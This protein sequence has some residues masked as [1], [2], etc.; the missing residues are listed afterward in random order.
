[1]GALEGA[2]IT[3]LSKGVDFHGQDPFAADTFP[4]GTTLLTGNLS[5]TGTL[6]VGDSNP[7]CKSGTSGANLFPSNFVCNPTTID[8]R[9]VTD[10]SQG[11]GAIFVHGWGHYLQIANNRVMNNAGTLGGG[12]NV[13][14]GEFPGAY[15]LGGVNADPGSC[16]TTSS[17]GLTNSIQPY[18]HE[19]DVNV[20]NNM[21][22]NNSSTGDELFSAT[23]AGAGGV[24]F[25]TGSDYYKFNNNWVCGNLGTG[26]GGGLGHLG[27]SYSADIEHNTFLFNQSTNP[28]I[29]TNGGAIVIMGAPDVDPT[30]GA[31]T[32]QD[33]VPTPGSIGPSD[34]TGPHTVINA[35][36]FVGNQA[37][38]GSGGA[39]ALQQI[40]GSDIV[41]FP[42]N[43]RAWNDVTVTNNIINNNVAG[44]D[45][46]GISLLD[47]LNVN[48]VNNTIASN[49]STASAGPL[50][51]T[52]G[53][54]LASTHGT[55]CHNAS[56]TASC[57]QPAGLVTEPNSAVLIAN[58]PA[59]ITCPANHFAGT[60]ASNGTCRSISYPEL[61]NN[62]IWQNRS[63]YIGVSAPTAG[64]TNQQNQ[65]TLFNAFGTTLAPSQPQ[66]DATT[67]NGNGIIV[68]GGTGACTT[69]SYWDIGIRGDTS[70][71][72]GNH[73][74]GG[75]DFRLGPQ[76]SFLT[77]ATDYPGAN[78][79]GANPTV[80][81]QYCN[82]SRIPPE[83][84]S[85][86][87]QVP[88]GIS[89]ATVPNPIFNL[90]P[91]ATVDEGN[92]WVNIA[93]G[94]L[95]LLHPLN[96]AMTLGNY[97]PAASSPAI[98]YIASTAAT[99]A[100][101]PALDFFG[102]PR[103]TTTNPRVD[104]GAVEVQGLVHPALT[105]IAPNSGARGNNVNVTLTGTGLTGATTI[106]L[107][108]TGV[109]FNNLV[110]VSDTSITATF[111]IAPTATLGGRTVSVTTPNGTSNN[112]TF[113][114]TNPPAPT[115]ALIS[116]NTGVRGTTVAVTLTGTNFT[117]SGT[118]VNFTTGTGITVTGTTV[119][120]STTITTNFVI[121]TAA[122]LGPHNVRVT[123]PGGNSGTL[124]FTVTG[125]T[126]TSISP[127][128]GVRGTVVDVTLTGT[129]LTGATSVTADVGVAV[130]NFTA[131]SA[132]SVTATFTIASNAALGP[133]A[134]TVV[135]P[136]GSPTIGFR[137]LGATL[138]ISAPTPVLTS[139]PA[140]TNTKTGTI[141]VA[142]TA[143]GANAGTFTFS[144]APTVTKTAGA[145]ASSFSITG[146]SCINGFAI[147]AGSNC[148][149]VV[150]YLPSG[151]TTTATAHVT[152][153]GTGITTAPPT[154]PSPVSQNGA[155]FNAN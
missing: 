139:T 4:V 104:V 108:G 36:L 33:C 72:G 41:S 73:L 103:K 100:A 142:N 60:T 15:L 27:F 14:Q 23:P 90:T 84:G 17:S 1:M 91:N 37:E 77:D 21:V 129:N 116:P 96:Q 136:A 31:T 145:A 70:P 13:G 68:T 153:T 54:P 113:T 94:P 126:L 86:G 51:D 125:A 135:S 3:V 56:G 10:S 50:F 118:T 65:V 26:D 89:D 45:G 47:A 80:V 8:G 105:S 143:T 127:V 81:S 67:S 58:L 147:A 97:A 61:Y 12:I 34:G 59:T 22:V 120:N 106:N 107:S 5:N 53:A 19:V 101:A 144:S 114:V 6:T 71:T 16:S 87:F 99:Y 122:G 119:V 62:L 2:G 117:T 46:G 137:I 151:S 43:P 134:V 11:G 98:D 130:S 30:C 74:N 154:A 102:N 109:T 18:C 76:Y 115:L 20:H 138:T 131:V 110:V 88:P 132:T 78:N 150:Q 124:P 148:T 152:V 95:S 52:I 42:T 85:M 24:N 66:A 40:N 63:F 149:I 44:W 133:R 48:I 32:D 123:T 9:T 38:S 141:T 146:G 35:N 92:N 79:N 28:T 121:A 83:L 69:A 111:V 75:T 7:L 64:V 29:P 140:N 25:C 112:V 57:P 128:S 49:D 93:W 155:N 39:I 55:N 82:G